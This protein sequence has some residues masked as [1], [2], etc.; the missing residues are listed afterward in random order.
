VELE[1]ARGGHPA[2]DREIDALRW[3]LDDRD[4]LEPRSRHVTERFAL[5]LQGALLV[6]GTDPEVGDAF[7]ES[8]L[9]GGRGLTFGTL[10]ASIPF[11][12][13]IEQAAA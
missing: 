12:R 8:R 13:L 4:S 2:L 5:A 6:R 3:E 7:C 10:P 9:G 1:G 11:E